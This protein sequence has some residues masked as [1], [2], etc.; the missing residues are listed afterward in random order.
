MTTPD[1]PNTSAR[2]IDRRKVVGGLAWS[3]PTVAVATAAPAMAVSPGE[4][5]RDRGLQGWVQLSKRCSWNSAELTIDGTGSFPNRGLWVLDTLEDDDIQ[6][7]YIV[8]YF[9]STLGRLNWSATNSNSGWSVP[10]PDASVPQIAG[11]TAYVTRYTGTF[12]FRD[13]GRNNP[14]YHWANGQP[15]FSATVSGCPTVESYARRSVTVNDE[16]ITFI[17]GPITV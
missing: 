5:I 11:Y 3:V 7:V 1:Q 8:F 17:R 4:D 10:Q 15:R 9:S 14:D 12:T 13:G 2:T 16:Q 6:D